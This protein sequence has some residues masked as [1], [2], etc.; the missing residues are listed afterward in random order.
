MNEE[1]EKENKTLAESDFSEITDNGQNSLAATASKKSKAKLAV[2]EVFSARNITRMAVFTALSYI[3]YLFVKFPLPMLFPSFLDVQISEIPALLAGFM[4]GP[5]YGAT[6]IILKC[7]LKMPMSTTGCVGE[8]ADILIGCA[9]VVT[10]AYIYK[11]HRTKKGA[12]VSLAF[13]ALAMTAMAILANYAILVPLYLKILPNGWTDLLNML[14]ALFP[15]VSRGSFFGYYLGAAILPFNLFRSIICCV[16][17][18]FMYKHLEKLFNIIFNAATKSKNKKNKSSAEKGAAATSDIAEIDLSKDCVQKITT[19][20]ADQTMQL[21]KR[22]ALLFS[23]GEVVL[24]SGDLGAGKTVF[25]KGIAQGL[26]VTQSVVSPTFTIMNEY[27]GDKLNFYHYDAYRLSDI[28]EADEAGLT[29][30]F[31]Q[32]DSV[33]LIE[34]WE[35]IL[36]AEFGDKVIKISI[37]Y[38]SPDERSV[39][40]FPQKNE[41]G[42]H[43]RK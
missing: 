21:A 43:E 41:V 24:V 16:L 22:L 37:E 29:Q 10:S 27:K 3:L 30:F 4:L 26:G 20:S 17:T 15:S 14:R 13:G 39:T 1:I 38:V 35:N 8:L 42:V 12:I 36:G 11:Y 6:V 33:C 2:K 25:A 19:H 28:S 23:G 9:F 40:V 5:W 31:G 18:F 34:W 32:S 7:V